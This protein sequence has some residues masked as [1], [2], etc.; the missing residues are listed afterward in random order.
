VSSSRSTPEELSA[1]IVQMAS[2][3][4]V[5]RQTQDFARADQLRIHIESRGYRVDDGPSGTVVTRVGR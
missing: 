5:A 3:R 1:D 4:D 2:E